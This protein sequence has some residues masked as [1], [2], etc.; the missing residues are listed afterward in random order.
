MGRGGLWIAHQCA[1]F[2]PWSGTVEMVNI[3]PV[4][5]IVDGD[6]LVKEV[7]EDNNEK[8]NVIYFDLLWALDINQATIQPGSTAFTDSFYAVTGGGRNVEEF[9]MANDNF[10]FAGIEADGDCEISARLTSFSP[11]NSFSSA[12]MAIRA[13][14]TPTAA[15]AQMGFAT[16]TMRGRH[17]IARVTSPTFQYFL[18]PYDMPAFPT[19]LR[20][21]RIGNSFTFYDSYDGVVWHAFT[22]KEI[23]MPSTVYLGLGVNSMDS[24]ATS[25][26]TFDNIRARR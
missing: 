19:W 24:T 14:Q 18:W 16:S 17:G 1:Y 26:A 23:E 3:F 21:T 13:D 15:S 5:A 6:N 25:T 9:D 22:S 20:I 8:V 11:T 10:H 7:L 4:Q 12:F 2:N